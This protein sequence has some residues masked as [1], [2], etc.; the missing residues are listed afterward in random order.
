MGYFSN[1]S[2]GMDYQE[3]YCFRCIHWSDDA[4]CPVWQAH[5]LHN[6]KECNN[7]S[8]ILHILIPLNTDAFND[9]CRMF[10]EKK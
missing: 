4:G 6:Y 9:Q 8:S 1:G 2:E 3:Q 5:E 7:P 10:I